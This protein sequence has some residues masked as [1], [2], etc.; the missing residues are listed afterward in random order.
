MSEIKCQSNLFFVVV[1]RV[2]VALERWSMKIHPHRTHVQKLHFVNPTYFAS[3]RASLCVYN[4]KY[5]NQN[6]IC[7]VQSVAALCHGSDPCAMLLVWAMASGRD[8]G[9]GFHFRVLDCAGASLGNVHMGNKRQLS[10]F[11]MIIRDFS[12]KHRMWFINK[13]HSMYVLFEGC[14]LDR[15]KDISL[16]ILEIFKC[17]HL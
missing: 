14:F 8:C 11:V 12:T 1:K 15:V 17:L 16:S 9:G 3:F 10:A 4:H 6:A 2:I 7:N 5:F 13:R